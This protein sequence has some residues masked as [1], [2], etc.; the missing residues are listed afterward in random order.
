[1]ADAV[2]DIQATVRSAYHRIP[3]PQRMAEGYERYK[4]GWELRFVVGDAEEAERVVAAVE[5]L[6]VRCG[7][8][9]AKS[10]SFV[11]PVY[12]QTAIQFLDAVLRIPESATPPPSPRRRRSRP[13]AQ[14]GV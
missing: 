2:L 5:R 13:P 9:F 7:Q 11:V 12:G 1:M 6:G 4:K 3:D 14:Q 10:R 8:P